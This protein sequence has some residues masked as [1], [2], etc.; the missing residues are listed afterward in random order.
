MTWLRLPTPAGMMSVYPNRALR[1]GVAG[2]TL[3]RCA[4]V[5]DGA[6][7]GC[8]VTEQ[9]PEGFGF[10]EA[11]LWLAPFLKVANVGKG[12]RVTVPIRWAPGG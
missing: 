3:M 2:R 9:T 1:L 4:V 10:G 7:G 5:D 11:T 6:V 8:E 12:A